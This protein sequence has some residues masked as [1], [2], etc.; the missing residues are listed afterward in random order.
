M[1]ARHVASQN[2][3]I[4]MFESG[5]Y[6]NASGNFWP[7]LVQSHN[8]VPMEGTFSTRYLGGVG[9]D[10]D[11]HVQGP[12][13][14]NGELVIQPQDFRFF[15]WFA[16]SNVD[17]GSPS[18][19]THVISTINNDVGTAFTSGPLNPFLSFGIEETNRAT[20][21]DNV[22]WQR[23]I[24]GCVVDDIELKGSMGEILEMNVKY[25]GTSGAFKSGAASAINA[26]RYGTAGVGSIVDRPYIF[27]DCVLHIPSGTVHDTMMNFNFKGSNNLIA[28]HYLTGSRDAAAPQPD[29][30]DLMFDVTF[31][32][33]SERAK[34]LYESY[35]QGGSDFNMML[36]INASTGSRDNA[37]VLSGCHILDPFESPMGLTGIN[38]NVL[39]IEAKGAVMNVN[40]LM[41]RYNPW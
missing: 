4:G 8:V 12:K 40:D 34:T 36:F 21:D 6:G 13:L 28:R 32:A 25:I 7:G 2:T 41:Q 26:F 20:A 29:T 5:T 30:R 9:R 3:V 31:D 15:A 33:Q 27:S 23:V 24:K 19:H 22:N 11:L 18:P 38:P 1:C 14:F 17:A 37:L 35:Y 39:H 16:G 10:V